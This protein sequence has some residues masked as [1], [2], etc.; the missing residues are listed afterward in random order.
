MGEKVSQNPESLAV[1]RLEDVRAGDVIQVMTGTGEK[2]WLYSLRVEETG[3]PW[4]W[5]KGKL[6]A[7]KPTGEETSPADF[8]L[9]GSGQW[10]DRRQNPVQ[11][12]E[13]AFSSYFDS[14]HLGEYLVGRFVG[15]E[16]RV[17]FDKR[18]QE[19]TRIS[20]ERGQQNKA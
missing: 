18:G 13:R 19:V 16:K 3:S 1:L 6:F 12:Q 5:P 7:I 17:I 2:A 4:H 20:C 10:T 14:L 9:H 11:T 8:E 15:Q